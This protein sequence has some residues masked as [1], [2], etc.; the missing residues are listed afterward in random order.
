[1]TAAIRQEPQSLLEAGVRRLA[2]VGSGHRAKPRQKRQVP[3]WMKHFWWM[4]LN[5]LGTALSMSAFVTGLF[6]FH[7]I[8]GF[9]GLGVAFLVL[10]YKIAVNRRVLK[11]RR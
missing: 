1:M 6:V 9:L 4:F 11:S 8:A 3:L 10:D 7:S 2:S 5:T